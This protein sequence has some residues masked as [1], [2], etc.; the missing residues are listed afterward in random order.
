IIY[1]SVILFSIENIFLAKALQLLRLFVL[2]KLKRYFTS[3]EIIWVVI[4]RKREEL[5]MTLILSLVIMFVA[6]IFLYIA[7]HKAQPEKF[8]TFFN[9]LYWAGITLFTIGF[10]DLI[11]ITPMG[12]IIAIIVS[13]LGITIFLLP[14]SVIASGFI[15][16]TQERYPH[17]DFC[18]NCNVEFEESKSL[19]DIRRTRKKTLIDETKSLEVVIDLDKLTP[20][21]RRKHFVFNALE[22]KYPTELKPRIVAF[23]FF[24][25]IALNAFAVLLESNPQVYQ[26]FSFILIPFYYISFSIFC[27]EYILRIWSCTASEEAKYHHPIK[28]R[29]KFIARPLSILD[30]LIIILFLPMLVPAFAF[31][32][33]LKFILLLRFIVVFKI[34]HFTDIFNIIGDIFIENRK[35]FFTSMLICVL[36]LIFSSAALYYVEGAAQPGKVGNIFQAMWLGIITYTTVGYGDIYPVT[37]MGRFLLVLFAFGG[38]ALFTLPA[39]ILGSSFFSSMKKYRLHKICPRCGHIL[40]IPKIKP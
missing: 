15:D 13:L 22:N 18:P 4:K 24:I 23:F 27:L 30:L 6:A 14:A 5:L 7:E 33:E 31:T 1:I 26:E 34:S 19:K 9:A 11:P 17:Y 2:L 35:I 29:L 20:N 10:G 28:G 32:G 12:K 3:F 16:E 38:V 40:E 25:L 37:T 39:G 21:Q 36:Y 8:R